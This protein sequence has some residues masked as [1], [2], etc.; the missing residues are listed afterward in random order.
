[1]SS[2]EVLYS[3]EG[4]GYGAVFDLYVGV[5]ELEGN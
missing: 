4:G 3:G 1:M 5:S 2:K